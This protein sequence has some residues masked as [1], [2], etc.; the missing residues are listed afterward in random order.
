MPGESR[1]KAKMSKTTVISK[2]VHSTKVSAGP[3]PW[4]LHRKMAAQP[5]TPLNETPTH[6]GTE[7]LRCSPNHAGAETHSEQEGKEEEANAA[8]R[9]C[10]K[11]AI[12]ENRSGNK[13]DRVWDHV[14]DLEP[15]NAKTQ[16]GQ[17]TQEKRRGDL[18]GGLAGSGHPGIASPEDVLRSERIE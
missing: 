15:A 16:G 14:E 8:E 6:A 9:S 1:R 11:D 10:V 3:G 7:S 2:L 12:V 17:G 4:R 5:R 13:R 18:N